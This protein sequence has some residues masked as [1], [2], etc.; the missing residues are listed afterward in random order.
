MTCASIPTSSGCAGLRRIATTTPTNVPSEKETITAA[1]L[2]APSNAS[3][4]S[5]GPRTPIAALK[6]KLETANSSTMSQTQRREVNSRQ[7]CTRSSRTEATPR[8]RPR[9]RRRA[10]G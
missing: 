6:P 3:S 2:G 10:R 4:E 7:P 5:T 8:A 9:A 1:Q